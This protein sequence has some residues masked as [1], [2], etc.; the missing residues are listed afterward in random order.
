MNAILPDYEDE[1]LQL[2]MSEGKSAVYFNGEFKGYYIIDV[3]TRMKLTKE[4]RGESGRHGRLW[5]ESVSIQK[6]T[7]AALINL[8]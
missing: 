7:T 5:V 2:P 8:N 1:R 3:E 6:H 4:W